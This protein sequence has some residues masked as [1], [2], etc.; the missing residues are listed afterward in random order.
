MP[1]FKSFPQV[2]NQYFPPSLYPNLKTQKNY[3]KLRRNM[4]ITNCFRK[5]TKQTG[6]L[7]KQTASSKCSP[8]SNI[9]L[10]GHIHW[11]LAKH[12]GMPLCRL[13]FDFSASNTTIPREMR[14][15]S[16]QLSN[17]GTSVQRPFH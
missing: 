8:Q 1:I 16:D 14:L 6:S 2:A 15:L 11:R 4:F 5:Q 17:K 3:L 10:T 12:H 7:P 13:V 9:G